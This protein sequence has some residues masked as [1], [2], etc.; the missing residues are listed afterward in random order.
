MGA[1][2]QSTPPLPQGPFVTSARRARAQGRGGGEGLGCA[3]VPQGEASHTPTRICAARA[4]LRAI[5][6]FGDEAERA[7]A[8]AARQLQERLV[9]RVRADE[10]GEARGRGGRESMPVRNPV[11]RWEPFGGVECLQL[12]NGSS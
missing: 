11:G 10:P 1:R 7:P 6:A 5:R 3:R 2:A 8:A 12:C 4:H 9:V